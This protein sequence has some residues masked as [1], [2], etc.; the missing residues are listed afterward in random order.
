MRVALARALYLKPD[1][2]LLDEPTNMLDMKAV[3]WLEDY[4]QTWPTTLL[5]VSHDRRF[6]NAIVTD[7]FHMHSKRLDPYKGDY[8]MFERI[9]TEKLK[10]Q[11]KEYEAL[12]LQREHTQVSINLR[13]NRENRVLIK[14]KFISEIH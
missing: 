6:L 11:Q 8:D 10:N 3:Y 14:N 2:L 5:C 1:L 4:L 7:V 12:Q 13:E 9:M